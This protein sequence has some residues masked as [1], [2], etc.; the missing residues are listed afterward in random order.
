MEREFLIKNILSKLQSLPDH[1]LQEVADFLVQL[2]KEDEYLNSGSSSFNFIEEEENLY[3]RAGLKAAKVPKTAIEI[4]NMLPD[5]TRCEVLFNQLSMSPS[6]GTEH[7]LISFKLSAQIYNFLEKSPKGLAMTAPIDVYFEDQQSVVQPDLIIILNENKDI[8]HKN[9]IYGSPDI[10]I[11]ILSDNHLHDTLKKKSLYEK[12]LVKEYFMVDPQDKTVFLFS[13]NQEKIYELVY[14]EKGKL[15][16]DILG[17][18]LL[19]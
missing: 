18:K 4:F 11:E 17:C 7:Q 15:M 10:I 5:G 16:S 8:I 3:S 12:A 19:I 2:S 1:T 9:S 6:P 13:L 14:E